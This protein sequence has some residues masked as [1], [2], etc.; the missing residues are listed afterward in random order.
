MTFCELTY[1]KHKI[2]F[3]GTSVFLLI[4]KYDVI[5]YYYININQRQTQYNAI[6]FN[7]SE[8]SRKNIICVYQ[9]MNK[10][11]S[12]NYILFFTSFGRFQ[13]FC[14]LDLSNYIV[15]VIKDKVRGKNTDSEILRCL[16]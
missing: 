10:C 4:F 11:A 8:N 13:T 7:F 3:F 9:F 5:Y 16:M 1:F 15:Y 12:M 2:R 14:Y 6:S